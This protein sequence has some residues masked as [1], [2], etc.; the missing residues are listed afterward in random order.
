VTIKS[1]LLI[2]LSH[3]FWTNWHATA[4]EEVSEAFNR[5]INAVRKLAS[6]DYDSV[7]VCLDCPPYKRKI[8]H[9]TYKAQ[10]DTPEPAAVDQFRRIKERL[11]A[12]GFLLWGA[13]GYEAD[14]II[15]TATKWAQANDVVT[16][17]ATNDKDLLQLVGPNVFVLSTKTGDLMTE[18]D[19]EAKT[20]VAPARMLDLLTLTGDTSDNVPGIPGV[21]PKRAADLIREFPTF[22]ALKECAQAGDPENRIKTP[23]VREKLLAN[24]EN[25]DIARELV[26]LMTD[27]PIDPA[28]LEKPRETKQLVEIADAEFEDVPPEISASTA[29][30]P[31]HAKPVEAKPEEKLKGTAPKPMPSQT[32]S[33]AIVLVPR[34]EAWSL[35]LEPTNFNQA[36]TVAKVMFSS[37]IYRVE[38]AEAAMAIIMTGRSLG[39]DAATSLRGIKMVEGQPQLSAALIEGLVLAS[40]KCDYFQIV[41]STDEK[42]TYTTMRKGAPS[43]VTMS[44]SQE[45]SHR[46][47]LDRP[48][49]NGAPSN[50]T[51]R[52]RT[53]FR[54]R[55]AADLARAVYPD[56][57]MGLYVPGELDE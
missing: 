10:R 46:E 20:G 25:L 8:A 27:A 21:G 1:L 54:W 35:A 4:Q 57:I 43:P 42:A 24:L 19:V 5:T 11:E 12:D 36:W 52:P 40:G 50:H 2:D 13:Q 33:K 6:S 39:L 22:E 9:P 28:D 53:M 32:E 18:R 26:T 49:R 51:K 17:I 7:A 23:G 34:T 30:A 29:R 16:T 48:T 41:D 31:E 44:Y 14:D 55:C 37:R 47:Q 56:V 15:A 45:D 38:S 3:L